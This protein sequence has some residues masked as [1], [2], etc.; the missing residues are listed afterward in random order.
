[1]IL[2]SF[3]VR[4]DFCESALKGLSII[5]RFKKENG[6]REV[7]F[8]LKNIWEQMSEIFSESDKSLFQLHRS[9]RFSRYK[10]DDSRKNSVYNKRRNEVLIVYGFDEGE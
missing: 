2:Y 3:V 7:L 5:T 1:V 4:Q 6:Y 10:L 8:F 9:I